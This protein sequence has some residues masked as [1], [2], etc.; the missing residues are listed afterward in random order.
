[1][2][3]THDQLWG[4]LNYAPYEVEIILHYYTQLLNYFFLLV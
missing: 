3:P 4:G 1:M 2:D